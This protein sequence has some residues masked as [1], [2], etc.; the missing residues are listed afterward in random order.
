MLPIICFRMNVKVKHLLLRILLHIKAKKKG[1][2]QPHPNTHTHQE[3]RG[4]I[5]TD[6]ET[7][8]KQSRFHIGII[9]QKPLSSI[10]SNQFRFDSQTGKEKRHTRLYGYA[11]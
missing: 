5:K 4:K 9:K 3:E 1:W 10:D 11:V 8:N 6:W 7:A 2:R